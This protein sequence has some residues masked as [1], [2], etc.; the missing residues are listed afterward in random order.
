MSSRKPLALIFLAVR[1][2]C[3]PDCPLRSTAER[4]VPIASMRRC[5][6][7]LFLALILHPPTMTAEGLLIG[8]LEVKFLAKA[9][10][11]AS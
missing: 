9:Y 6:P 4:A 7:L 1:S 11:I 2:D 8:S 3:S 10:A 5:G